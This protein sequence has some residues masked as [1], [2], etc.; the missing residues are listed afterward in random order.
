MPDL[1]T[2]REPLDGLAPITARSRLTIA[3]APNGCRLVFRGPDLAA[4]SAGQGFGLAL[5][6]ALN[7]AATNGARTA[8]KLGPDEWLLLG[9]VGEEANIC[10]SIEAA[11]QEPHSLVDVSHRNVGIVVDG[12]LAADMVN[13]GVMLNL[14]AAAF[15]VGMATRTV[16]AKTEIVLWR[17]GTTSFHVEVWRSFAPYLH[18]Q[19]VEASLEYVK[20]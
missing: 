12:A 2:R 17:K 19:L 9:P 10:A 20:D 6:E 14:D 13:V 18:G 16:F 1:A 11:V 3:A 5:P 7:T 4:A 15:P 8:F